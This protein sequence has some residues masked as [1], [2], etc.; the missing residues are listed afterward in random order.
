[1]NPCAVAR[2]PHV[3]LKTLGESGRYSVHKLFGAI[4]KMHSSNHRMKRFRS[5][6]TGHFLQDIHHPG[7]RTA[8]NDA[9]AV[10]SLYHK[11]DIVSER[12]R[13]KCAALQRHHKVCGSMHELRISLFDGDFQCEN[14]FRYSG[15][16]PYRMK[17]YR[18]L[19]EMTPYEHNVS[20]LCAHMYVPDIFVSP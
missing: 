6:G 20:F 3:H 17:H 13:F 14:V 19:V 15:C 9:Y 16:S 2:S 12:I 5:K 10:F 4:S 1:M 7:V 11:G 18:L 8:K